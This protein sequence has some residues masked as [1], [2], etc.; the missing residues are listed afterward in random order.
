MYQAEQRNAMKRTISSIIHSV[1]NSEAD[2]AK[3]IGWQR[4][5]LNRIVNG[6][7]EPSVSE[8]AAISR[9]IGKPQGE[10][11]DIFLAYWSPNG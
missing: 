7:K 1:F 6:S 4:Q 11:A 5:R 10:T 9:A 3:A 8:V 2:C